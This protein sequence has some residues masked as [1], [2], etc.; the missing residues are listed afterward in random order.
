MLDRQPE[1]AALEALLDRSRSGRGGAVV[2]RGAAGIGLTALLEHAMCSA[3]GMRVVS[4]TAV[5]F[6]RRLPYGAVH[7]ICSPML[8]RLDEL[9]GSQRDALAAAVGRLD[10]GPEDTLLVGQAVLAL[11]GMTA[12]ERALVCVIDDAEWIDDA[13]ADALAFVARRLQDARVAM[14]LGLHE[15]PSPRSPLREI[16][17]LHVGPLDDATAREL[18]G[19]AL[20]GSLD[21][22]VRD[23]IVREAA[24]VPI[25]L[26]TLAAALTAEQLAGVSELPEPLPVGELV[27]TRHL[28]ALVDMPTETRT[29]LLLAAADPEGDVELLWR[30][31]H[32][33]GLDA[34]AAR[35]A[36]VAGLVR[37]AH[38]V[39]FSS[40]LL[41]LAISEDAPIAD[42]Q[43]VHQA[44]CDAIDGRVDPDRHAWHRAA[45]SLVPN[46][47]IALAMEKAAA[48]AKGR[49]EYDRA[50]DLFERAA[51]LT[52]DSHRRY[53]RNLAAAQ[54]ALAA[55]SLRRAS[56]LLTRGEPQIAD[57][58]ERAQADRLR[59][60]VDLAL[61]E[62]ADR[63]T[64]LLRSARA[65]E[66]VDTRL[67][68]DTY[69]EA[70]EMA[71]YA[72]TIT[73]DVS[74]LETADA[75]R[76]APV[77]PASQA[78]GA[79]FLL[80]GLATLVSVGHRA[81]APILR[82]AIE[83]L[84]DT[85]ERRW[86][87]LASL[88][89]IEMWD[90]DGLHDLRSQLR[91]GLEAG[92]AYDGAP[93]V[94]QL[95]ELDDVLAGRFS[96][97]GTPLR[98]ARQRQ[99][100]SFTGGPAA[101]ATPGELVALAWRGRSTETRALAEACMREGFARRLGLY[102]AVAHHAIAVLEIGLGRY[103]AACTAA[104]EACEEPAVFVVTSTLPELVEAAVRS[105][106][107]ELAVSAERRLAKRARP[108]RTDWSLGILARSRALLQDGEAAEKLY[109]DAIEHLRRSRAAPQL[110]R[111]HL[112]YGEWLRRERRRREAREQLT[113]ARDMFIF[114]GAQAF[115]ERARTELAATGE[116][117]HR[118][119][120]VSSVELLTA[121]EARIAE[122]VGE[123]ASNAD[124][125]TQ[126]F[127]SPRTVEY[128][129]HKVFRKLDVS[130]R[131]QLARL[132]LEPGD[133]SSVRD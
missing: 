11:L 61:G 22:R 130:T 15:T 93:D 35:P 65:F 58:V 67:A 18:I 129:L 14:I 75:A 81:A 83:S 10:G 33:L 82:R 60:A 92:D 103:E 45:A 63:A 112:L 9:P 131:T 120:G 19:S 95:G 46:E 51:A 8:N 88:A 108:C 48:R 24:G 123:G 74:L 76:S 102:V 38:R 107:R 78:G 116:Q 4:T 23:R 57:E 124:I 39:A 44:I 53:R 32:S 127:I 43:R 30:A 86:L 80:D 97:I 105:G 125:A 3:T 70:L 31:A 36:E 37:L 27:R 85:G 77:V 121:Q 64:M 84:R 73:A 42:R 6:E 87:A 100:G 47:E 72:G 66:T 89:A 98:G 40:P 26:V 133:P 17:E 71:A 119:I 111:T 122:L 20:P 50:V 52:P 2:L 49:R 94:D 91:L 128:H 1:R 104:G 69:L 54:A 59:G 106:A 7:Q 21:S 34:T 96:T 16:P 117:A 115:A 126:L 101:G 110:A 109:R 13:S 41:R 56:A 5:E 55:G 113:A 25:A 29:F 62:G 90:D 132:L 28:R 99:D 118:R 114:M 12:N 79:D 68:R